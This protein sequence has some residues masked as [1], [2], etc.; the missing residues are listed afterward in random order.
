MKDFIT[1]SFEREICEKCRLEYLQSEFCR[2]CFI[3]VHVVDKSHSWFENE[4]FKKFAIYDGIN[5]GELM[6][7]DMR[8]IIFGALS[9]IEKDI[10]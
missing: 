5:L 2:D 6:D 9:A 1:N 3:D 10:R 8:R 7:Y 4:E